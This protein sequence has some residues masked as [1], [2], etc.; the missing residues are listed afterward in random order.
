MPLDRR[1]DGAIVVGLEDNERDVLRNLLAQLRMLVRAEAGGADEIG[2]SSTRPH[3]CGGCSPPPTPATSTGRAS[4]R[5]WCEGRSSSSGWP[6]STPSTR[7]WTSDTLDDDTAGAWM[8][9][10]ND[11]RLVVGTRLDVSEDETEVDPD[12]PDAH[13]YAVYDYLGFLVDRL[14][15]A[16][17]QTLPEPD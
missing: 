8:R 6:P 11:L 17:T 1:R 10:L 14:V 16:L 4:T 5:R 13:L 12:D 15:V 3:R 9:T 7:P 2:T